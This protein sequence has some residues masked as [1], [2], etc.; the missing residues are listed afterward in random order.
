MQVSNLIREESLSIFYRSIDFCEADATELLPRVPAIYLA[1]VEE[2]CL[3]NQ[4]MP[5]FDERR[6]PKL[7]SLRIMITDRWEDVYLDGSIEKSPEGKEELC[8]DLCEKVLDEARGEFLHSKIHSAL[9][10]RQAA[11]EKKRLPFRVLLELQHVYLIDP[12]TGY[13]GVWWPAVVDWEKQE[14]VEGSWPP[15]QP[16]PE[17]LARWRATRVG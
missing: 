12:F 3:K 17:D 10:K 7:Q 8:R 16:E 5:M 6:F 1:H 14:L 13:P 11:D 2:V 4:E 9:V 15:P